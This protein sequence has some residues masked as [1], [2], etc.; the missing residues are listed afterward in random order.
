[1]SGTNR[2][3]ENIMPKSAPLLERIK[4]CLEKHPD[5]PDERIAAAIVGSRRE[6]VRAIR[7]GEPLPETVT[8]IVEEAKKAETGTISLAQVRARYDIAAAI[9]EELAKLKPGALI[10]ERELS[11]RAAGKDAARFRR[12]VENVEEFRANRVKL[13]LDQDASEGAWYWGNQSTIAEAVKLRD[14]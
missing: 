10:L 5:W 2:E 11:Q 1:M 8:A 12:T 7:A 13:R 14:E 6:M 4:A 9:R 3:E